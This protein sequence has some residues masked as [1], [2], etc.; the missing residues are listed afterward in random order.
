MLPPPAI[1]QTIQEP[2]DLTKLARCLH[3]KEGTPFH[4]TN[5]VWHDTMGFKARTPYNVEVCIQNHLARLT[6]LLASA[7]LPQRPY[8]LALCW[9]RGFSAAGKILHSQMIDAKAQTYA[10]EVENLYYE[11]SK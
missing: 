8:D 11:T 7:G 3:L 9:L 1:I 4:I 10:K 2:T 5:A 6:H